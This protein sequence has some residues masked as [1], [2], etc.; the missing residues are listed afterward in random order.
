MT[1]PWYTQAE[2]AGGI[3]VFLLEIIWGGITYRMAN[4][5][6]CLSSDDGDLDF[7]GGLDNFQ[8]KESS[9]ILSPDIEANIVSCSVHFEQDVNLLKEWAAGNVL[10][11]REASFSY[12]V[13]KEGQIQQ[14]YE[15][16][17]VLMRG[18]IQEP[19]FG[20]PLESD[21]FAAFSIEAEAMDE[22]RLLL[23]NRLFIDDRFS[24]RDKDT[25][26]GKA[27]P[28]VIGLPGYL[29]D[30]DGT[31]KQIYATPA[32][33]IKSYSGGSGQFMVAAH[34]VA[35]TSVTIQDD[36]FIT[37]TK[38]VSRALDSKGNEYSYI[39]IAGADNIGI[40]GKLSNN[41]T[42][43]RSWWITWSPT[44]GGGIANPY[45]DGILTGGGDIARWAINKTGQR[46]DDGAWANI[47]PLLNRYSFS[48]YINDP[49]VS[50]WDWLAGNILP[51]LPISVRSGPAG[52]KPVLNQLS[53]MVHLE[54]LQDISIGDNEE[55]QQ[56]SA[57]DT[58]RSTADLVNR[59]TLNYGKVGYSQDYS[60]QIRCTNFAE[61]NI[62]IPSDYSALSINRYGIKEAAE[63]T[64]YIYER[65]SAEII[66]LQKVRSNSLPIR[67]FDISGP[68]HYGYLQIGDILAVSS[69]RLFLTGH[70]MMIVEKEW[71][72]SEWR[73]R[74][75]FE[76]NPIQN[77]RS[78]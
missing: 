40:P 62:D 11:G 65:E 21:Q 15:N 4:F 51:Y 42:A 37:A 58:L 52:L 8:F 61:E 72:G 1:Q 27:W 50:A 59:Y 53:S 10:E 34:S 30:P 7:T 17:I 66:A 55:F 26:D 24:S 2:Y 70:K 6:V 57:I 23:D 35:A 54:A 39:S 25:A 9:D 31:I 76:D 22:S 13:W 19:Q 47:T 33:C 5:P 64:D 28:I 74:L 16:R 12:V 69:D 49:D 68:F 3:P 46:V 20:D 45:G 36:Q 60:S 14:S 75:A 32:Y 44:Y 38:T 29:V 63:N 18:K 78:V 41:D 73:F 43:S 77:Q 56:I 48:G 71:L 67:V